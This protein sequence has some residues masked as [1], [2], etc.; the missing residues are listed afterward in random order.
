MQ[1]TCPCFLEQKY[2]GGSSHSAVTDYSKNKHRKCAVVE[3]AFV[4]LCYYP[5]GEAES[6]MQNNKHVQ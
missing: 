2:S 6:I 4:N 1:K 3:V 5:P